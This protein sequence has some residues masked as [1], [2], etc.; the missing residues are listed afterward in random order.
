MPPVSP[1]LKGSGACVVC[2]ADIKDLQ[3]GD[4]AGCC[5]A[6]HGDLQPLPCETPVFSPGTDATLCA[7]V[8]IS[9]PRRLEQPGLLQLM[10]GDI[11]GPAAQWLWGEQR[12]LEPLLL[13]MNQCPAQRKGSHTAF[14]PPTDPR[15]TWCPLHPTVST[16]HIS[17]PFQ[18]AVWRRG[19]GPGSQQNEGRAA[20]RASALVR[21]GRKHQGKQ[22]AAELSHWHQTGSQW[23]SHNRTG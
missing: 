20:P 11:A 23:I 21:L 14:H 12:P 10:H 22:A 4:G 2:G 9:S 13:A 7:P 17:H 15:E 1:S 16:L 3:P 6:A 5:S 19:P 18:K 8:I